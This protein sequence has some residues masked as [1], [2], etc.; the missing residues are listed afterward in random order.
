MIKIEIPKIN[1]CIPMELRVKLH[2]TKHLHKGSQGIPLGLPEEVFL[3]GRAHHIPS[4]VQ[5]RQG[6]YLYGPVQER[7]RCETLFDIYSLVRV[8]LLGHYRLV[9]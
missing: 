6:V 3:M 8:F 5:A 9:F 1:L 4:P 2:L 7:R